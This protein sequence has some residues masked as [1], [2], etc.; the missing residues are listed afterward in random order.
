MGP[1]TTATLANCLLLTASI[2]QAATSDPTQQLG[3]NS[4]WFPG[5]DVNDIPYE[6]PDG[7]SVDMAAFV[8]R[9]ASRYPDPGAYNGWVALAEKIQAAQFTATGDYSFISSWKPV[10]RNP[11]VEISD[12]SIGGYKELYD[13]G[14]A[15]RWRYP[16]FYTENTPFSVFANQYP[17]APRVVNSA[18]LFAR[19]YLGPN[20]TYGDVYVLKSNVPASI[21]NSLA[22]S[23][24]CPTYDDN[25]GGDKLTTWNNLYLPAV[26]KRINSHIHGNLTF[27]DSDV[28]NF[29]YLCGFE[30]QITGRRSPWCNIFTD[31][32]LRKY[33]YAQDLRYYYG[34]GPGSGKNYTLMQ[35]VLNAIVQRLVDGPNKGYVNSNGQSWTPGPLIPMFTNDGQI[36]QLVSEIGVFDQQKSLPSTKIPDDQIYIASHYVTMRGTINFERLTCSNQKYVRITLNDAVYPVP[37]CQNGPGKSCPLESYAALIAQKSQS[38]G[39][40]VQTCGLTNS[41]AV[42]AKTNTATFL[43][44]NALSWECQYRN[45]SE[46]IHT[47]PVPCD[48]DFDASTLKGKTAIVTGGANGLGEGYVRALVHAGVNVCFGDLDIEGGKKLESELAGIKF[49]KCDITSWEDQVHLFDAAKAF[50]PTKEIHYVV[51]NAGISTKDEVFEFN[52]DGPQKPDL[53]T[54]DVNLNGVLYTTKLCL[55]HFIKQSGQ[56]PSPPQEDTCLVLIGS[57][58]AFLDVARTPQYEATKWAVRGIMHSLRRTAHLFGSRVN[59]ISPWYVKTKVLSEEALE[60]VKSKGVDFATEEDAGQCLSRIL[61]DRDVNGHSFFLSPRKWPSRGYVDFDLEYSEDELLKEIQKA[62]LISAPPEDGLFV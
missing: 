56:T 53:K 52:E 4:P 23:D 58:A 44:D 57:G 27:T 35:P 41:T 29:P 32:E 50:S 30:T 26:T 24:S 37:S 36:N 39:S 10:L 16:D 62:Q 25:G 43:V 45:M 46:H 40:F 1:L 2:A 47:G 22:P 14:V 13:M 38:Q 51:A 7:C 54:I 9:H 33:E 18:R 17:A 34:S 55:H 49:V 5:P 20:S 8:S 6:V 42:A 21:A 28:T 61:S 60:H 19:G 11:A 3:G 15:Y 12:I 59:V 48:V 31:D